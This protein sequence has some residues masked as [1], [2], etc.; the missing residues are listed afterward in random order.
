MERLQRLSLVVY[1]SWVAQEALWTEA[2]GLRE[3]GR[4]AVESPMPYGDVGLH[5][6][7]VS[8]QKRRMVTHT[9][10]GTYDPLM[11]RPPFGT[12]LGTPIGTGGYN[13]IVSSKQA[14]M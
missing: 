11:I 12:T 13:R 9:F 5:F 14:S 6:Q 10:S 4:V 1:K 2:L 3:V 7:P 8:Y